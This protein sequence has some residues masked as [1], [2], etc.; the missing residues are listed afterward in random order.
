MYPETKQNLS[1]YY[2]LKNLFSDTPYVK[3]VDGFPEDTFEI[4]TIAIELD[5]VETYPLEMGSR[6]FGKI[7]RWFIDIFAANKSQRSEFS[8]RI[9]YALEDKIP[10]YD[11]DVAFPPADAPR[12][13][14][15]DPLD[16][17]VQII[18][19]LPE[20][21]EKMYYRAVITFT[22]IYEEV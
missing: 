4:P 5:K 6:S 22:A 19:V 18:K 15:I 10:V 7:S 13:G 11:Y 17:T 16:I 1:I 3:V 20:L 9:L 2:W 8:N 14:V 12:I 21:T